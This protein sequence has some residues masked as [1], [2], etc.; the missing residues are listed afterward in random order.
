MLK[1]IKKLNNNVALALNNKNEEIIIVGKGIGFPKTPYEL[2]DESVIETIYTTP[3]N[4]KA[5]DLLNDISSD[6]IVVTEEIIHF[7]ETYLK[8]KINSVIFLTLTDHINFALERYKEA[9]EFKNPLQWEIKHL[10]PAEYHIAMEAIKIIEN[11]LGMQLPVSEASFIALHFVNAQSGDKEMSETTKI[12]AIAGE[13]LTIVKYHF[14]IDFDEGSLNF[15]R[16]A[17]HIRYFVL[18]QMSGKILK[19]RNEAIY[20]VMR[21]KYLKE[22]NC[23]EKIEKY[24][25]KNYDWNC[26][27]D[28]KLYLLLHLQRLT[29]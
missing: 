24:V 12:I 9:I 21:E 3:K 17:T 14:K 20:A 26:S 16:F 11:R 10:Y 29:N 27:D 4:M 8:K 6:T 7:G 15:T 25:S 18:R 5:F 22:F 1:I 2:V 19:D 28:E 13:I 23:V